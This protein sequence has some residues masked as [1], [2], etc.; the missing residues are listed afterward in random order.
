MCLNT[1]V[2]ISFFFNLIFNF[3]HLYFFTIVFNFLRFKYRLIFL[4]FHESVK[5]EKH[6]VVFRHNL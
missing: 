5:L 6:Y 4:G 2:L 3:T 1:F